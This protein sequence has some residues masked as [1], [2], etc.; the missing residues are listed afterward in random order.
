MNA[1]VPGASDYEPAAAQNK[2]GFANRAENV[3]VTGRAAREMGKLFS[4]RVL[5]RSPPV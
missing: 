3:A 5:R 1:C 4:T 2:S